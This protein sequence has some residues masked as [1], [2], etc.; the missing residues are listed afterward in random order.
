MESNLTLTKGVTGQI[1][2]QCEEALEFKEEVFLL[3]IVRPNGVGNEV[4]LHVAL[5][6]DGD[7]LY[8]PH[9]L[10]FK[11]WEE[12][13]SELEEEIENEPPILSP[14]AVASCSCCEGGIEASE[15]VG[16]LTL[17]ELYL[18][19]R[20]PSSTGRGEDFEESGDPYLICTYCLMLVHE[21]WIEFWRDGI[22]ETGEQVCMDCMQARCWRLQGMC[23]CPCH[24]EEK[25]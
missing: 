14:N 17:G 8:E 6:D 20:A 10:H 9:F 3:Q 4:V 2:A 21:N 24:F 25:D 1:C 18:S 5:D 19:K 22:S 7:F 13:Q 16:A 23:Q 15:L 11:C 12:I